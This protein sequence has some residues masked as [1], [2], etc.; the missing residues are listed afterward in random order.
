MSNLDPII[1]W[2]ARRAENILALILATLFGSFLLQ[3]VFRYLLNLPLGWT[4]EFVSIAWLCG[5]LFGYAFVVREEDVIRLDILYIAL[6]RWARRAMDVVT[7]SIC[8]GIFI[9]SLPAVW[10]YVEF[11]AIE[12]T[13]YMKIPFD[14][15]FAVYIPFMLSVILRCLISV[16]R[17]LAGTGPAFDIRKSAGTHDYD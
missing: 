9:W 10:G 8:A 6:P 11:M 16:W 12:K 7:G 14:Y 3:I 1:G 5:I 17:G 4:V 2:L 15:V 13:A